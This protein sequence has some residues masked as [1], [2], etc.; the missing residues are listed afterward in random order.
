V[1]A[2]ATTL[3]VGLAVGMALPSTSTEN[4]LLG[5]A[6]DAVVERAKDAARGTV[7][8]VRDVAQNVAG[9]VGRR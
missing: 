7:R 4:S 1:L 9:R 8:N 3:G 5:N 6:R 2:G